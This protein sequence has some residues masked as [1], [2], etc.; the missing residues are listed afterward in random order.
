MSTMR[1]VKIYKSRRRLDMYLYVDH[2]EDLARVPDDLLE[3]FGAPQL[4]MTLKLTPE[5]KLARADAGQVL[6]ALKNQGFFLQ[7]PPS[8]AEL[9][10]GR[11]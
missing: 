7:L 9:H 5:R 2:T 6:A 8:D 3:R 4:A 11:T 10:R 1:L